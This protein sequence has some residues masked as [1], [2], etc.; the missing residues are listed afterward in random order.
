MALLRTSDNVYIK[1]QP[2]YSPNGMINLSLYN[3]P[4][5]RQHEKDNLPSVLAFISHVNTQ[6]EKAYQ[7]MMAL[8]LSYGFS[9]RDIDTQEHIDAWLDKHPD[10]RP[11]YEQHNL[12]NEASHILTFLSERREIDSE[13]ERLIGSL[14]ASFFTMEETAVL[15]FIRKAFPHTTDI[16][17]N[18]L[19]LGDDPTLDS[20]YNQIR[21]FGF[22]TEV[23]DI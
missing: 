22:F 20:V 13:K 11:F 23:T 1:L 17:L 14:G 18:V 21:G 15:E 8:A 3:S 4:V 9:Q 5:D 12:L 6:K 7:D 10:V 16:M 2:E 19:S